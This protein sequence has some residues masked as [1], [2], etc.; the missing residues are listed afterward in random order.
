M[1][2]E[3]RWWIFATEFARSKLAM[4]GLGLLLA[5]ILLA[6]LAPWLAPQRSWLD[7][8]LPGRRCRPEAGVR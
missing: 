1:S 2:G 5:V 6:L 3:G 8:R 4:V 7:S